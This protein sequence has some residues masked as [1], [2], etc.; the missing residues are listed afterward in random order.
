MTMPELAAELT[1][2]TGTQADPA[3]FSRWLIR[4]GYRFKKTLAASEQDRPN[5]KSCARRMRSAVYHWPLSTRAV[6]M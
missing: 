1:T 6:V 3:S 4:N 5:I 2:A